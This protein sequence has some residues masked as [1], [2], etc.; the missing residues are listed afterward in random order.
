MIHQTVR[1]RVVSAL[2]LSIGLSTAPLGIGAGTL[3]DGNQAGLDGPFPSWQSPF[4]LHHAVGKE[5]GNL[6]IGAD[7]LEFQP[8]KGSVLKFRFL[9]VR[10]FHLSPHILAIETYQNRKH[11]IPGAQRYRFDVDQAVPAA[12]A[13]ALAN[14]VQR[15]SQNAI[16]DPT[17]QGIVIAAYHRTPA[18][19]KD[20]NLRLRDGGIDFVSSSGDGSRSW[21]WAD[22][23]TL[24]NSDP[25][26]LLV[27]GY[28]DTYAFDLREPLSRTVFNHLSDEIWTHG[29]AN[30]GDT[31]VIPPLAKAIGAESKQDE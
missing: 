20:G 29:A 6:T 28:R 17:A 8:R 2:V 24:S 3:Q 11:R 23:Q 27:F 10:T 31:P 25:Y 9:D 16:P 12:V 22:L 4:Q 21:R 1:W 13:A 5:E 30:L 7:G 15:P 26:R 18:G 14:R 19:G